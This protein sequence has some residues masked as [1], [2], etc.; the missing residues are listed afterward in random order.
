MSKH[1][2]TTTLQYVV[3]FVI[4]LLFAWL[5]LRELDQ[6]KWV[7]LKSAV[8]RANLWLIMPVS[9]LLL[10]SHYLRGM[11]WK[12]L[13]DPMG[14]QIKPINSFLTVLVG[15]LV[16][17]GMPRLGELIRCTFLSRYEKVEVEKLVGTVIAERL[18]DAVCLL[19]VFGFTLGLQPDL[20][21]IVNPV[22]TTNSPTATPYNPYAIW[23]IVGLLLLF[24]SWIFWKKKKISD[25]VQQVFI[26]FKRVLNGLL[27]VRKLQKPR[28][29]LLLT[30]AIWIMYLLSGYIGFMAFEATRIYGLTEALTI[31]AVGSIGM[32]ISPGG[33]GAYAYL[34]LQ[35]MQW[36][37][38]DYTNALAFGWV[39]WLVQTAVILCGGVISFGL[40]PWVNSP[41]KKLIKL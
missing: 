27:T 17:L 31:L 37:G 15:Y 25:I 23:G 22:I 1:L 9:V 5:S 26:F 24:I 13:I 12:L 3:F 30:L 20:Y 38:L 28:I 21:D 14:Y 2:I 11:R 4:G 18:F 33:I 35:T 6:E 32:I 19:V 41:K 7:Q 40:L 29:F 16:N 10:L 36:Y 39:L 34:I 8:Q